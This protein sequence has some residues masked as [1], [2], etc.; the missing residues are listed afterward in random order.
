MQRIVVNSGNRSL[1][2]LS[3]SGY[4]PGIVFLHGL[5]GGAVYFDQA[6]EYEQLRGC[7]LLA[8]DLPGFGESA[9]ARLVSLDDIARSVES[10]IAAM[11]FE[12]YLIVAHSMASSIAARL[13][14]RACGIVLVEGNL[15]PAH[16]EFS[17]RV[18]SSSRNEFSSEFARMQRTARMILRY[19]TRIEDEAALGRYARTWSACSA[20][21][22]WDV[23][24][25]INA[26]VRGGVLIER[27]AASGFPLT[28]VYGADGGY[29]NTIPDVVQRLPHASFEPIARA[30]HYPM[31]DAPNETYGIVARV[32]K[33]VAQHA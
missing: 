23:A 15:L 24:S 21:T 26:E 20:D 6:F 28:C 30:A 7:A 22:V 16:L 2:V 5:C 31:L 14:C 18:I 13:L 33:E 17:D 4:G 27:F 10:A 1:S 3:R 12:T 9:S 29:A 32:W 8:P 11:G 19:Q 25:A